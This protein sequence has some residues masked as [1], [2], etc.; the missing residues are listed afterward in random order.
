MNSYI[1]TGG[2]AVAG[3]DTEDEAAEKVASTGGVGCKR[4]VAAVGM[5]LTVPCE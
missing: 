1:G 3:V 5:T 2:K 4:C